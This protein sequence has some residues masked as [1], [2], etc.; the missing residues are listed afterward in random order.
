VV[1]LRVQA[2]NQSLEVGVELI[3]YVMSVPR[4]FNELLGQEILVPDPLTRIVSLS[5]AATETLFMLGLGNSV[6]GVSAFCVRPPEARNKRIIGTYNTVDLEALSVLSPEIIFTTTGF[7]RKCAFNLS[8]R[9]SVCPIPLPTSVAEIIGSVVEIGLVTGKYDEA[10]HFA[11]KLTRVVGAY[12]SFERFARAYVELDL[13]APASFGAYSYIT[14]ALFLAGGLNVFDHEP[15]SWLVPDSKRILAEDPEI[16][17]YEPKMLEPFDEEKLRVLLV[18]RGWASVS[19][20]RNKRAFLVPGR[21]LDFL[22]HHGPS[23][24]TDA[25]PWLRKVMADISDS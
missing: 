17:I 23:F 8:A 14:D 16:I 7:Q 12:E 18:E 13:G 22:A 24:V 15:C 11:S 6:I 5:P 19:A 10:R 2:Q 3:A 9:F 20:V 1:H 4:V 25:L 21:P